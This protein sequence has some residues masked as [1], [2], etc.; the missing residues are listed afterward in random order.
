MK[1]IIRHTRIELPAARI[2]IVNDNLAR[3]L[4][5]SAYPLSSLR[6]SSA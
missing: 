2:G 5:D 4:D 3:L 6:L 1:P